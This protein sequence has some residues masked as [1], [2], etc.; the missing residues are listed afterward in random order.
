MVE[1]TRN[2]VIQEIIDRTG[3]QVNQGVPKILSNQISSTIEINPQI[4]NNMTNSTSSAHSASGALTLATIR[5][6]VD[7]YLH[8]VS[9]AFIKDAVCDV[10]T[11]GTFCIT[12][13]NANGQTCLFF[14]QSLL[15]LTAQIGEQTLVFA[16]PLKLKRGT[17]IS[18]SAPVHTLGIWVKSGGFFGEY[19][20][21]E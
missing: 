11:A 16:K 2:S 20:A 14:A 18:L 12:T 7:F 9:I 3:L 19:R 5:T 10:A 6:D 4:V 1:I 21:I 17:N 13:T 8:G 15:T